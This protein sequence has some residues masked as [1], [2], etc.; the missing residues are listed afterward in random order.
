MKSH[1]TRQSGRDIPHRKPVV[2]HV[3]T[4]PNAP[5]DGLKFGGESSLVARVRAAPVDGRANA[6]IQPV[7]ANA[8]RVRQRQVATIGG[9]RRTSR[10]ISIEGVHV[11]DVRTAIVCLQHET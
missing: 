9:T 4:K 2:I 5:V 8:L 6:A 11:C 7:V 1:V 10:R 3:R